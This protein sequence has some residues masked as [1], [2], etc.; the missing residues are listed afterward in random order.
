MLK[1]YQLTDMMDYKKEAMDKQ[2]V[3]LQKQFIKDK[4]GKIDRHCE[5][6]VEKVRVKL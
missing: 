2:M 4:K 6:K 3:K 1:Q 5:G